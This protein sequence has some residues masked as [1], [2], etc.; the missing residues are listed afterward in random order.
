MHITKRAGLIGLI[1]LGI[2]ALAGCGSGGAYGYGPGS[3]SS[4][5]TAT[6]SAAGVT[7]K[8]HTASVGGSTKTV[9][10]DS[11]GMTLYYF[12][13]DTAHAVA[14]SGACATTWPPL[15]AG[16]GQPQSATTL[17]GSLSV[18]DG[19]NGKQVEYNGHPLYTYS[20]DTSA[21]QA[22]GDGIGGKWHVAT[23]DT[24]LNSNSVPPPPS[25]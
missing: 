7:I 8:T 22:K 13:P 18:L 3:G 24:P 12:D 23:P 15:A 2:A 21:G 5:P 25:Y 6:T 20:G 16:G 10:T 9:L 1:G 19:T 11:N 17:A 14:C 4:N